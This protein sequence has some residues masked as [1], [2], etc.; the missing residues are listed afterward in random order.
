MCTVHAILRFEKKEFGSHVARCGK[1][2]KVTDKYTLNLDEVTC[3]QCKSAWINSI[4]N[5]LN[6]EI[7]L[8]ESAGVPKE[9]YSELEN[10][11]DTYLTML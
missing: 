10:K 7:A 9:M 11:R 8:Y 4:V 2:M 3:P 6:S 1:V 5:E